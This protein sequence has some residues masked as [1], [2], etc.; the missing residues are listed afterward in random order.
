MEIIRIFIVVHVDEFIAE[1]FLELRQ[2]ASDELGNLDRP[3]EYPKEWADLQ[4][5]LEESQARRA[6]RAKR[7]EWRSNRTHFRKKS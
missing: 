5:M 2:G 1:G 7:R 4:I 3:F 6:R